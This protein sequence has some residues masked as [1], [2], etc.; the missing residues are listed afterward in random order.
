MILLSL[1]V[2]FTVGLV[3]FVVI[4][5]PFIFIAFVLLTVCVVVAKAAKR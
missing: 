2:A 3:A 5:S 1:V 4:F